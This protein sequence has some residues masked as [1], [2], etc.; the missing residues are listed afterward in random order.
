M[1]ACKE[2][3]NAL[4]TDAILRR[5]ACLVIDLVICLA[6]DLIVSLPID[7][8][9]DLVIGLTINLVIG[10]AIDLHNIK[11]VSRRPDRKCFSLH[12]E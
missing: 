11:E 7:L 8:V 10:L 12:K 4:A 3:E 2:R 1:A 9:I 5:E 6:V